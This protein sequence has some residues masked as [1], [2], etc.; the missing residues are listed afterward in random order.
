MALAKPRLKVEFFSDVKQAVKELSQGYADA[1][2]TE[3][4]NK[5]KLLEAERNRLLSQNTKLIAENEE[6][7]HKLQPLVVEQSEEVPHS[8]DF[9]IE[10]LLSENTALRNKLD[11]A[12]ARLKNSV[13]GKDENFQYNGEIYSEVYKTERSGVLLISQDYM[14]KLLCKV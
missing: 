11:L 10:A 6:L 5:V 1:D 7:H 3:L 13:V 2:F 12:N 14:E 9:T 8:E 4:E